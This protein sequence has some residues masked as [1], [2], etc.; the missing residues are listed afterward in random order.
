MGSKEVSITQYR[1]ILKSA[2][3]GDISVTA[4]SDP[5]TK[6]SSGLLDQKRNIVL[7]RI[8]QVNGQDAVQNDSIIKVKTKLS[9]NINS[10]KCI[11]TTIFQYIKP[12][13]CTLT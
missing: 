4:I 8:E 3:V 5:G 1:N 2:D 10:I 12:C 13:Y 6:I 7:I 11:S 9:E